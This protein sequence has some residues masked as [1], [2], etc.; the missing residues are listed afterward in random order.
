[1]RLAV[2]I[3]VPLLAALAC[4]AGTGC[5]HA[6]AAADRQLA[7]LRDGVGTIQADQ[8][9]AGQLAT[10]DAADDRAWSE[11]P[12]PPARAAVASPAQAPPPR[13]IQIGAEGDDGESDDPNDPT[14]RPEIRIQGSAGAARP[15]RGKTARGRS[16]G[17]I[18]IEPASSDPPVLDPEAKRSYEQARSHVT[19]KQY[20]RAL[21]ELTAFLARW[22]DHPYAENA[23]YWR[24]E[25]HFARGEH[26]RAAEQFEAVIARGGNKTPDALL[27]LGMCQERLGAADR[28]KDTWNRLRRDYARS[29]AA[30]RL[31]SPSDE[32]RGAGPKES[33]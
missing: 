16:G 32:P 26:A 19:A 20:D 27:K 22:P 2:S 28:A 8:D 17:E 18:R 23:L 7:R 1:M 5:A 15:L 10:L 24:G 9:K 25:V 29:D 31:P 12:P 30:K 33:R 13:S 11:A 6:D 3:A 21:E 14:A 4:A